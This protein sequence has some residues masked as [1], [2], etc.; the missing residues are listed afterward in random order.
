[1]IRQQA[2]ADGISVD[3]VVKKLIEEALGVKAFK[4]S[5]T[6]G[7]SGNFRFDGLSN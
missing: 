7:I 3:Q 4:S 2:D 5:P 6:P 1:M